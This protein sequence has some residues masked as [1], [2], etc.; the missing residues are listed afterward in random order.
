VYSTAALG[1]APGAFET[2]GAPLVVAGGAV[3]GIEAAARNCV[4]QRSGSAMNFS[5]HRALQKE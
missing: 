4:S 5:R 3:P 2:A 1:A